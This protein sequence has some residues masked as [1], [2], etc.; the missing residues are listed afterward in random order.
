[1]LVSELPCLPRRN[2]DRRGGKLF[3][4]CVYPVSDVP[5]RKALRSSS[6]RPMAVNARRSS[7]ELLLSN[8][9]K[10]CQTCVKNGQCEL[11]H[12]ANITGAQSGRTSAR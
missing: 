12:V 10:D 3:A 2:P 7:V 9:S 11:L 4:S 6:P 1:V 5:P 8:H